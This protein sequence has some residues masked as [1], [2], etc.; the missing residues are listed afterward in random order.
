MRNKRQTRTVDGRFTA[1][2][3][4]EKRYIEACFAPFEGVYEMWPGATESYARGAFTKTVA[5]DDIRCLINHDTTLVLGRNI[6]GTFSLRE[7]VTGLWGVVEINPDDQ[8]AMNLY[9]RVQRGDVSQCSIGF[10][11]LEEEVEH[12]A[13][14]SV[15]WTI[16][17]AKLYEGSIC[18]FPAY[19]DTSAQARE[20]E[21]RQIK[22][23][24]TEI[25]RENMMRRIKRT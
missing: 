12:R 23:R 8:D 15:H 10:D 19:R 7:D 14:G 9:A 11:I 25:W 6:A 13:D 18:T 5:E 20:E 17:E 4:G 16:K 3:E 1:R 2:A 24:Q 22:K 21:Y